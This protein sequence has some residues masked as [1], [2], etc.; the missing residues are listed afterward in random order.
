MKRNASEPSSTP[1]IPD[2][3]KNFKPPKYPSRLKSGKKK[4]KTS[5]ERE[6]DWKDKAAK[7][8]INCKYRT[9]GVNPSDKERKA[10]VE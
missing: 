10:F 1:F 6:S 7:K 3:I 5:A 9:I 8:L 4:H 2:E